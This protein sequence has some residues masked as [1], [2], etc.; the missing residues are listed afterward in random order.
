MRKKLL[1]AGVLVVMAFQSSKV[2]ALPPSCYDQCYWSYLSC[3]NECQLT[4]AQCRDGFNV[5]Y[6]ACFRGVGPWFTC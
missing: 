4:E 5:C 3:P 6:D 1:M 2:K